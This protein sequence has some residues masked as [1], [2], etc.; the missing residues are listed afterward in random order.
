MISDIMSMHNTIVIFYAKSMISDIMSMHNTI[1]IFY[2]LLFILSYFTL[3][4]SSYS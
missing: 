2:I 1:V 4:R 3:A